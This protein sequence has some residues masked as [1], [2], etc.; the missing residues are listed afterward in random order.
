M[1][2]QDKTGIALNPTQNDLPAETRAA[3]TE[4]LAPALAAATDLYWQAKSAHWN[5][6]GPSFIALH[7]L[8]DEVA[9]EVEEWADLLAER[10][11]QLGG[12]AQ[13]TVQVAAQRSPLPP[14][15]LTIQSGAEHVAALS[16]AL[17]AFGRLVRSLIDRTDSLGDSATADVCT[18]I[19]RGC[20]KLLWFVEAHNQQP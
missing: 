13:G 10:I 1:A 20:D 9:E 4:A 19:A 17:A 15:P 16:G 5:V 3:V 11:V 18:E 7:K 12:T 14:Y 6:K 2:I 8:F